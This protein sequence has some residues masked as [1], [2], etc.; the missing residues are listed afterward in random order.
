[1]SMDWK[2]L[3]A[4]LAIAFLAHDALVIWIHVRYGLKDKED[5]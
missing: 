3:A 4:I 5:V 2:T 1:M